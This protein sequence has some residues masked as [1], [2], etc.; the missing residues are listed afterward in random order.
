MRSGGRFDGRGARHFTEPR[1]HLILVDRRF[2]LIQRMIRYNM[3]PRTIL[4][5]IYEGTRDALPIV[6]VADEVLQPQLYPNGVNQ[7][8]SRRSADIDLRSYS[9]R[10]VQSE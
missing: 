5:E 10:A 2:R 3:C 8:S 9:I 1:I 6:V 4:D 7:V